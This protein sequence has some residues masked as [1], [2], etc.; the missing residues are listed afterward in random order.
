MYEK[1]EQKIILADGTEL[2]GSAGASG[3]TELWVWP[4]KDGYSMADA[5]ADF[6]DEE[7]TRKIRFEFVGPAQEWE[8]FTDLRALVKDSNERVS[9]RLWKPG[10]RG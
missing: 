10:G 5:F 9:I 8:G 3:A 1:K 6:S 2:T 7:K 4:T